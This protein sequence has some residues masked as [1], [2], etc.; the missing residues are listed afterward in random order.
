MWVETWTSIGSLLSAVIVLASPLS[1]HYHSLTATGQRN[2]T[3]PL[4]SSA[5][6]PGRLPAPWYTFA[7]RRPVRVVDARGCYGMAE[8]M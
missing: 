6:W 1:A 5:G 2:V 7:V 4:V 3:C 8:S